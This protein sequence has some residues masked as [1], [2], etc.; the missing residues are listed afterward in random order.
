[1]YFVRMDSAGLSRGFHYRL[2]HV[3]IH[4]SDKN[5]PVTALMSLRL[6]ENSWEIWMKMMWC[7]R[8]MDHGEH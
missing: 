7:K 2:K 6:Y 1:M 3:T 4:L 8:T 5:Q